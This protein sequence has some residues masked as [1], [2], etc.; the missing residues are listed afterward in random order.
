M[1]QNQ[2][3]AELFQQ[4]INKNWHLKKKDRIWSLKGVPRI[5]MQAPSR[6]SLGFSLDSDSSPLSNIFEASPPLDIAKICD[7][8]IVL[9]YKNKDYIFVIEQKTKNKEKYKKQL[10]NGKYFCDWL[11][12][13]LKEHGYY[14]RKVTFIGLLCWSPREKFLRKG[15]TRHESYVEKHNNVTQC[16]FLFEIRNEAHVYLK[17][18]I[19]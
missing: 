10:S 16:N 3:L 19:K 11:L 9:S 8:I 5:T 14:D 2:K 17:K 15:E 12:A 7:A 18:L 4:T 1:N 6:H 13:L